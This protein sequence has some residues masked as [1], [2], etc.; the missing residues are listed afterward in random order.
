MG[1]GGKAAKTMSFHATC[2]PSAAGLANIWDEVLIEEMGECLDLEAAGEGV[3]VL[4]GY[5]V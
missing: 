4:L 2:H 1:Y 5:P 3:S